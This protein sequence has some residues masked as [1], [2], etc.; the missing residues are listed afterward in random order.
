M[1]CHD[2][3]NGNAPQGLI[4]DPPRHVDQD[5]NVHNKNDANLYHYKTETFFIVLFLK[6]CYILEQFRLVHALHWIQIR[7][8]S[9]IMKMY[10]TCPLYYYIRRKKVHIALVR[11]CMQKSR[12][13]ALH[14]HSADMP[15]IGNN[16]DHL[17]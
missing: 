4:Y 10:R 16:K 12:C 15:I 17:Q 7:V 5:K 1:L 9:K 11:I 13:S 14:P 3:L 2:I 8:K 6:Y